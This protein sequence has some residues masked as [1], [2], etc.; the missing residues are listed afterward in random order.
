LSPHAYFAEQL[1]LLR[2]A[3]RYR[4]CNQDRE[5]Q[6]SSRSVSE[7]AGVRGAQMVKDYTA[8]RRATWKRR[9]S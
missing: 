5:L 6:K 2:C 3:V 1:S 4:A 9:S 7:H 8:P